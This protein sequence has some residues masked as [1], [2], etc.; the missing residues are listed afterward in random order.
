MRK[1]INISALIFFIWLVIDALNIPHTLF[2]FLVAGAVPGTTITVS[3][4]TMLVITCSLIGILVFEIIARHF[5]L[6]RTI[7]RQLK[8]TLTRRERLPNRRFTRI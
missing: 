6:I 8:N 2:Y 4:T 3:S 5:G 7:K 1:T